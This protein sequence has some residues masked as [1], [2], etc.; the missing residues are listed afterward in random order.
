[1]TRPGRLD[2]AVDAIFRAERA[3]R[4]PPARS[5]QPI[6]VPK[7]ACAVHGRA[8]RCWVANR[9]VDIVRGAWTP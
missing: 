3:R 2:Y 5:Q 1:M 9:V 4:R 7:R 8:D 6:T